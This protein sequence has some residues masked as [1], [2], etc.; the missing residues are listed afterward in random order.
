MDGVSIVV[1]VNVGVADEGDG[2][3]GGVE[4]LGGGGVGADAPLELGESSPEGGNGALGRAAEGIASVPGA[5]RLPRDD[6]PE[7]QPRLVQAAVG[8]GRVGGAVLSEV[9]DLVFGG[10]S[11]DG[12]GGVVGGGSFGRQ[13]IEVDA[14]QRAVGIEG[15]EAHP[16]GD[17]VA[18]VVLVAEGQLGHARAVG[19]GEAHGRISVGVGSGAAA[20]AG[21]GFLFYS[22]LLMIVTIRTLRMDPAKVASF[23]LATFSPYGVTAA[24]VALVLT[25]IPEV[26]ASLL[27]DLACTTLRCAIVLVVSGALLWAADSRLRFLRRELPG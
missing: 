4:L 25:F 14:D 19:C 3:S 20:G 7:G 21:I 13:G 24:T 12:L 23:L 17:G 10:E 5:V 15:E 1:L 6:R 22:A 9:D 16:P 27:R 26:E 18:E 8:G 2:E 11:A